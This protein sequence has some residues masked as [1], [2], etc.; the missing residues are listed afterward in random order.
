MMARKSVCARPPERSGTVGDLPPTTTDALPVAA[1]KPRFRRRASLQ[2]SRPAASMPGKLSSR[3]VRPTPTR[4]ARAW[5][6]VLPTPPDGGECSSRRGV[7][8]C[9]FVAIGCGRLGFSR[10]GRFACSGNAVRCPGC[11]RLQHLGQLDSGSLV[12]GALP[13]WTHD[14]R[15]AGFAPCGPPQKLRDSRYG[16]EP[17]CFTNLAVSN[18]GHTGNGRISRVVHQVRTSCVR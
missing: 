9:W 3:Y 8:V 14:E 7:F 4:A 18:I 16:G 5:V 13:T 1:H 15:S 11:P 17:Q 12:F 10:W 6:V 2:E